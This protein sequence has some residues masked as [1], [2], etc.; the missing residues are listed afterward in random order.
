MTIT[1]TTNAATGSEPRTETAHASSPGVLLG[2]IIALGVAD[3][4]PPNAALVSTGAD[5]C[6]TARRYR[7]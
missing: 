3:I 6:G 5:S 4:R 7:P 2:R 1:T